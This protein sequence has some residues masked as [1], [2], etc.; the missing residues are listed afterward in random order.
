M[1]F[2]D[3]SCT[4]PGIL[5][6]TRQPSNRVY[7]YIAAYYQAEPS[8]RVYFFIAGYY[9]IE[10]SDRVYFFIAAQTARC[11]AHLNSIYLANWAMGA[12][13]KNNNWLF[14]TYIWAMKRSPAII[15]LTTHF[16]CFFKS[17]VQDVSSR[18]AMKILKQ[19]N[20]PLF[21][22]PY[23]APLHCIVPELRHWTRDSW[24]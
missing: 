1:Y 13:M 6:I 21:T 12:A 14:R 2:Q 11:L 17:D 22:D 23:L 8:D 16:P 24:V 10:P 7:F 4:F 20:S 9:R 5:V 15:S 3:I 19:F 18:R